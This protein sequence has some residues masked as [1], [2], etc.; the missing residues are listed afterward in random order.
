MNKGMAM[1][2]IN[3]PL[4]W[5]VTHKSSVKE[6]MMLMNEFMVCMTEFLV[7]Y[8]LDIYDF[9]GKDFMVKKLMKD[10]TSFEYVR[11]WFEEFVSNTLENV[12]GNRKSDKSLFVAKAKTYIDEHFDDENLCLDIVAINVSVNSAYL[13][14]T[15]KKKELGISVWSI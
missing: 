6:L 14:S 7:E 9:L 13:S 1:K 12:T 3:I 15:F 11:Q 10:A 5:L 2:A 4:H 8:N